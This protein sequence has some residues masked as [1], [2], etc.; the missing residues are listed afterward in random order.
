MLT[1]PGESRF[2]DY[3]KNL[4]MK[5]KVTIT[6]LILTIVTLNCKTKIKN[7]LPDKNW[8][9]KYDI[10]GDGKNDEIDYSFSGG[11]HCCYKISV[12]LTK[13]KKRYNFPFQMDGGYI[14]GLDL[15]CKN[16][17]SIKDYDDDGLPEIFMK[18]ISKNWTK[19][20]GI[21]SNY[22][23]IEYENNKLIVWDIPLSTSIEQYFFSLKK[24]M[25]NGVI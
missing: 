24:K 4:P 18:I 19:K 15:S 25:V 13:N 21:K 1:I 7:D 11:A 10:D 8:M 6:L 9:N 16:N 17:F 2:N 12:L 5:T 22:I 14:G 20:Y 23:V 3:M